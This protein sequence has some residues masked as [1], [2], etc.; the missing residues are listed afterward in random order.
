MRFIN[1]ME[2]VLSLTDMNPHS[3]ET[4]VT[5]ANQS[6]WYCYC[7]NGV[8]QVLAQQT[9]QLTVYTITGTP[10]ETLSLQAGIPLALSLP[11]GVYL[12]KTVE[13]VKKLIN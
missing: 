1:N 6:N 9:M 7:Q 5:N 11:Q 10:V 12:L 8:W 4:A 13:G 3:D 2:G